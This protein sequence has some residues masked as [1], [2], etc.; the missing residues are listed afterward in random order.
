[1]NRVIKFKVW[2]KT[3]K[4][5]RYP[6]LD[7]TNDFYDR[8]KNSTMDDVFLQFTGLLDKNRNEIYE[9]DILEIH[10]WGGTHDIIG[11]SAIIWCPDNIGWDYA[12]SQ[13]IEDRYDFRKSLHYSTIIGNIY[14]NPELLQ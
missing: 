7:I 12:D 9:G 10:D 2:S 1:M 13:N 11:I 3:H 14:E 8:N 5:W 4:C 6:V